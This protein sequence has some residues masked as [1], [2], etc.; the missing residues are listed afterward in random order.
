MNNIMKQL[1]V[2]G[3]TGDSKGKGN[4]S[5]LENLMYNPAGSNSVH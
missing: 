2:E 1:N 5:M 3:N 4:R